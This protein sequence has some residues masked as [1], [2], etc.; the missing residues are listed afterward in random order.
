MCIQYPELDV[1]S[2]LKY[3]LIHFLPK[4]NGLTGEDLHKHLKEFH[5]LCNT[6]R[7]GGVLEEH[8]KL[9]AFQISLQDTIKDWLLISVN[10]EYIVH[11]KTLVHL[12]LIVV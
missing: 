8:I 10:F 9:K 12:V 3:G 6:I 11:E 2:K 5:I 7:P 4:F 1:Q